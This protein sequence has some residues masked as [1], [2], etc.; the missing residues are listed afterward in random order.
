MT[1]VAITLNGEAREAPAGAVLDLLA[2]L[3]L[4]PAKVAGERNRAIVPKSAYAD[5]PIAPGDAFEI[6]HIVGGG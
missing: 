5:T 3:D 2:W 6:V 4:P 1:T